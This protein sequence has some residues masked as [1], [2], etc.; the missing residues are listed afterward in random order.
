MNKTPFIKPNFKG[1]GNRYKKLSILERFE[2][3]FIRGR[4]DE[5]WIWIGTKKQKG[6]GELSLG[7]KPRKLIKAHRL[8]WILA[9]GPI[10]DNL[11][12]LHKC[13]QP[14]CVN[15]DHLFLG[16]NADNMADCFLKGRTAS[17]NVVVE[18]N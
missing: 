15:P 8:A 10:P 4:Q 13:D 5:C 11:F 3:Q 14:S 2:A 1:F 17:G 18:V 7:I 9:Y 6:Y 16:T 12:V